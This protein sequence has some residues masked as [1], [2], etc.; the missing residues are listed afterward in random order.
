[1][2]NETKQKYK[3]SLVA[4]MNQES[5]RKRRAQRSIKYFFFGLCF[6][7]LPYTAF[8]WIYVNVVNGLLIEPLRADNFLLFP[9][10][11][12]HTFNLDIRNIYDVSKLKKQSASTANFLRE[13]LGHNM[14]FN[15]ETYVAMFFI[16]FFLCIFRAL[17]TD[18]FVVMR[19]R[20]K[21]SISVLKTSK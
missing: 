18:K 14:E 4:A 6:L 8:L 10:S 20:E 9:T 11:S 16:I 5:D 19:H 15:I 7:E 12:F 13:C 3:Q 17:N 21:L 1:M 2:N